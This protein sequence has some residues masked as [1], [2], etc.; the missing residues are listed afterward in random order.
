[1]KVLIVDDEPLAR[2]YLR[3]LLEA[4]G[5]EV[6][7]ELESATEALQRA[8]DLHPDLVFLD[9]QMPGMNGMQMATA[10]QELEAPPLLVFVTGYSEYALAAFEHDSIDYLLKPVSADRLARTLT[11]ATVR[12]ADRQQRTPDTEDEPSILGSDSLAA[13]GASDKTP[14]A[15]LPIREDFS[16]RL[17][18][19]DDII[20]AAAR[21]KRVFIITATGEHR[22]YY[23]LKQLETILPSERFFR[24]HDSYMVRIDLVKE[25]H[26][27]GSHSYA[28]R[29]EGGLLVPVGRARYRE[30]QSRLGLDVLPSA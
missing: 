5:V 16:V 27:L 6:L 20:C 19:V 28:I 8:E 23:T 15:R 4:Q 11:R 10:L 3:R 22:T 24:V 13:P 1:M 14:I 26:L 21:E 29:M 25:L 2:G 12:L 17:L 30:L 9:I 18:R 7:A